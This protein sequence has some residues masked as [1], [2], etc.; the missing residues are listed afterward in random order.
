MLLNIKAGLCSH[1]GG[2]APPGQEHQTAL[3]TRV[4]SQPGPPPS[5]GPPPGPGP[6]LAWSSPSLGSPP[7]LLPDPARLLALHGVSGDQNEWPG[8]LY[9][10]HFP[11]GCALSP[12]RGPGAPRLHGCRV[13]SEN[14]PRKRDPRP[15]RGCA[16][17]PCPLGSH[18]PACRTPWAQHRYSGT[19]A[20]GGHRILGPGAA[21]SQPAERG[22]LGLYLCVWWTELVVSDME[23]TRAETEAPSRGSDQRSVFV[24][25]SLCP[26]P[27]YPE[28]SMSAGAL[29]TA[30]GSWAD[31]APWGAGHASIPQ[32]RPAETSLPV[33]MPATAAPDLPAEAHRTLWPTRLPDLRHG[34]RLSE[35]CVHPQ[36]PGANWGPASGS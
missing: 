25:T 20:R 10:S 17:Q 12:I 35:G 29:S 24:T 27:L 16:W 26:R 36:N 31:E 23:Q 5:L 8:S 22:A 6:L 28:D 2:E 11:R 15:L 19:R 33:E 34:E 9:T 3:W 21:G 30:P 32:A 18:K 13:C 7:S 1:P 14:G 4:P